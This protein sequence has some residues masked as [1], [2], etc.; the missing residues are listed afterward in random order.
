ME[1][2]SLTT[3]EAF[4]R[5]AQMCS[6]AEKC[7]ADVKRKIMEWGL[8]KSDAESVVEQLKQEKF[9]DDERYIKAYVRD[10]FNID[11]WGRAK[12][13]YYL[14]QKGIH[15][16]LIQAGLDEIDE[17]KYIALLVKTMKEKAR[18]LKSANRFDKMAKIIRFAQNRGFEPEYIHRYLNS[19]VKD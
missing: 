5:A 11:K 8:D 4:I 12:I 14:R 6:K 17:E 16:H 1:T 13:S 15:S 18:T 7:S 10:K 19:V 9:I 2:G 3:K